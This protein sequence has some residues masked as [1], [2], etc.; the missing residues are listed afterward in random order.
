MRRA[1]RGGRG[2]RRESR[3]PCQEVHALDGWARG[4]GSFEVRRKRKIPASLLRLQGSRFNEAGAVKP[5]IG[6]IKSEEY[7]A[8]FK[9]Q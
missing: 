6:L 2:E 9:L 3:P 7:G 1:G 5:R 4:G 8:T